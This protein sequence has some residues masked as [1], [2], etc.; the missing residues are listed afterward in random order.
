[1]IT[2][3]RP[4]GFSLVEVLVALVVLAIGLIGVAKLFVVTIQGN[5]SATSRL[6]AVNL[7]A[8]LADR[9]R[10]D[11]GTFGLLVNNAWAGYER[12]L[13]PEMIPHSSG[14]HGHGHDH[15]HA[16]GAG[17]SESGASAAEFA[18]PAAVA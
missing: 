14:G 4:R 11:H 18:T 8:D 3:R 16:G 15:G 5:A 12:A 1:M 10:A 6:Y 7:G 13:P 9:I 17:S 2:Q